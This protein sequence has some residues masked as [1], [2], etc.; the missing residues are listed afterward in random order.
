MDVLEKLLQP[1]TSI[2][3]RH[4]EAKTPARELCKALEGRLFALRVPNSQLIL[5]LLVSDGRLLLSGE[6]QAEPD[7]ILSGSPIAL[8]RL[9]GP[10]GEELI[11]DGTVEISG[12]SVTANQFRKLIRYSQPDF[13]EELSTVIGDIPAHEVGKL[14][15]GVQNWTRRAHETLSQNLIDYLQEENQAMP[16]RYEMDKFRTR[17]GKLRDD[18][19]RFEVKIRHLEEENA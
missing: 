7:V 8:I 13:E 1:V 2:L 4:I 12:D 11:R 18:V 5:N 19:A 16:N 6:H 15:G 14:V 10:Y 3:N 9:T 17:V